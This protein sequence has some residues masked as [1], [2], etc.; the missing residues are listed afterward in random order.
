MEDQRTSTVVKDRVMRRMP[1]V[2]VGE[3]GENVPPVRRP[4]GRER[5]LA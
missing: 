4:I 2:P 1:G 3:I 5:V